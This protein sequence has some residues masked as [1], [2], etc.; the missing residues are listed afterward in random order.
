LLEERLPDT[1]PSGIDRFDLT[2]RVA[3]VTGATRGLGAALYF[4]SDASSF[5]TGA[6]LAVDGGT[7]GAH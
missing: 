7:V 2:G 4:A 6:V 5:T 1:S 3:L